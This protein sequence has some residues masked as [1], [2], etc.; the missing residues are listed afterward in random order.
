MKTVSLNIECLI[1][2]LELSESDLPSFQK[3]VNDALLNAIRSVEMQTANS[4]V[5]ISIGSLIKGVK[6][7]R[8][9]SLYKE[10]SEVVIDK[11]AQ[12]VIALLNG[13]TIGD[14]HRVLEWSENLIANSTTFKT[15]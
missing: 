4:S 9:E 15:H 8:K 6:T 14:I 5:E 3:K 12:E 1:E 2:Q 7:F 11:K 10:T 13:W